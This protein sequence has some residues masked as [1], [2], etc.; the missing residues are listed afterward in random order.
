M[1]HR[2]LESVALSLKEI[3]AE[4]EDERNPGLEE[5]REVQ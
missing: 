1:V 2:N 3:N 5:G 4:T